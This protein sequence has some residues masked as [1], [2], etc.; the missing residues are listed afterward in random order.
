M[1]K[2][3]SKGLYKFARQLKGKDVPRAKENVPAPDDSLEMVGKTEG[4]KKPSHFRSQSCPFNHE[5]ELR[6]R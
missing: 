4:K 5:G 3:N 2:S 1:R 6:E